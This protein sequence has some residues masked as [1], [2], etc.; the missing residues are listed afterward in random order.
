MVVKSEGRKFAKRYYRIQHV[1]NARRLSGDGRFVIAFVPQNQ[2]SSSGTRPWPLSP[3][4][5]AE[6]HSKAG[7]I[8]CD[9]NRDFLVEKTMWP[10]IINVEICSFP[11]LPT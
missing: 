7:S 8:L 6:N 4:L 2:C 5:L 3:R 11:V 9:Y 10:S 1:R